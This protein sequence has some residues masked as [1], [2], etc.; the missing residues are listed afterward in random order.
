MIGQRLGLSTGTFIAGRFW[1]TLSV[2]RAAGQPGLP[3][4]GRSAAVTVY[5][6][7]V[8]VVVALVGG[9][10]GSSVEELPLLLHRSGMCLHHGWPGNES[11]EGSAY[12]ADIRHPCWSCCNGVAATRF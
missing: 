12:G 10:G 4:Q 1:Q 7:F 6:V 8:L 3:P 9:V 2:V 11:D 5:L